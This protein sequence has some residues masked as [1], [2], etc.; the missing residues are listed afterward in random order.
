MDLEARSVCMARRKFCRRIRHDN[1][2]TIFDIFVASGSLYMIFEYADMGDMTHLI[3]EMKAK[4]LR[5]P[6]VQIWQLVYCI[7]LG[8]DHLHS[9]N[10]MH[11]DIKPAN[12]YL[13]RSGD[14]KVGDLGLGRELA[15]ASDQA[16]SLVGTPY[17]M[18]PEIINKEPYS[19]KTEF[20]A[21][22]V[23]F[24]KPQRCEFLSRA[25]ICSVWA[26][27]FATVNLRLSM[28]LT[29]CS[30]RISFKLCCSD[31]QNADCLPTKSLDLHST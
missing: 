30:S 21:S 29:R 3:A 10:I 19:F 1:I 8:L 9:Q 27:E 13:S 16:G 11:R 20:G 6:E 4:G 15:S 23:W 26:S 24:M 28:A 17:Y 14:V 12:I 18:S 31:S 2:I 7:A 22:V 25:R 5:L